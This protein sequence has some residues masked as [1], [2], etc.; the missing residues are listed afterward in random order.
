MLEWGA[1]SSSRDLP[2]PG[3]EPAAVVSPALAGGFF[4]TTATWEAQD[5]SG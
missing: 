3:I 2:E 4:I 5:N 1:I